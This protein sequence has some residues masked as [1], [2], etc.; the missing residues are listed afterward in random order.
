MLAIVSDDNISLTVSSRNRRD[1]GF[2]SDNDSRLMVVIPDNNSAEMRFQF[3]AATQTSF[4]YPDDA[5]DDEDYLVMSVDNHSNGLWASAVSDAACLDSDEAM[6]VF[7][8]CGYYI[9]WGG[10]DNQSQPVLTEQVTLSIDEF[11]LVCNSD[12]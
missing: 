1:I 3:W 7:S 4:P 9:E 5:D 2:S 6:A 8:P 11:N 10:Q 12:E